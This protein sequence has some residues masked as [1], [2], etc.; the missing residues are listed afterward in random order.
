MSCQPISGGVDCAADFLQN[1]VATRRLSAIA[2]D[3]RVRVSVAE[4]CETRAD[5]I[6]R[7]TL[8]LA[9]HD[10]P[11]V[12]EIQPSL[13]D[14][15]LQYWAVSSSEDLDTIKGLVV[16]ITVLKDSQ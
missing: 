5:A 16:G 7:A 13:D 3:V 10:D 2:R 1:F 8:M 6:R 12:V 11:A 4:R 14:V 9:A 15:E